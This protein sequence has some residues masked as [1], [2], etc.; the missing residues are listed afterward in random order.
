MDLDLTCVSSFLVLQE[1]QHFGRAAIR[2]N[3]TSSALTKRIRRLEQ[4]VGAQLVERGPAG[5]KAI[6][7][8]GRR[9]GHHA[10]LLLMQA[11]Q[12]KEA[13]RVE[14]PSSRVVRLGVPGVLGEYPP[15]HEL[16]SISQTLHHAFPDA[17]LWF[18]GIPFSHLTESLLSERTDVIWTAARTAQAGLESIP[19]TSVAR[20]GVVAAHHELAQV[21]RLSANQFID[22][23]MVYN[24]V[25]PEEWMSL[26]YFGDI[27]PARQ[28]QLVHIP[29]ERVLSV[30]HHVIRG[31]GVTAMPAPLASRLGP[32]LHA[33][34]IPDAP[35]VIF[36]A[37]HRTGDRRDL[38]GALTQALALVSAASVDSG[39][40]FLFARPQYSH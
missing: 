7:P 1:E 15:P 23:P 30:Y 28:A 2:L 3:M 36:H 38:V 16:R 24:P 33:I 8:A 35:Q 6:T 13:A 27:R 20:V 19:L 12:A 9:F 25:L 11:M 5:F 18:Q 29:A 14:A 40:S 26:W 32:Q 31:T 39:S 22:L 10:R 4:Q 37:V 17:Q 21:T 34:E